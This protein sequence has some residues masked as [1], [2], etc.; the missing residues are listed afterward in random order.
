M[1]AGANVTYVDDAL[2]I[3]AKEMITRDMDRT[4][5][6]PSP[7]SI[8]IQAIAAL[9][10]TCELLWGEDK[11]NVYQAI[12]CSMLI[13]AAKYPSM[14]GRILETIPLDEHAAIEPIVDA[15]AEVYEER[16]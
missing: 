7:S 3:V 15:L 12:T 6:L 9:I 8:E 13:M 2:V 16:R 1:R 14:T 5:K 11:L 10:N 4:S